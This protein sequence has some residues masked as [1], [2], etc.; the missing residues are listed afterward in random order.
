VDSLDEASE[1]LSREIEERM[2]PFEDRLVN[3]QTIP[4]V[5]DRTAEL[6]LSEVDP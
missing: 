2:R 4:G 6:I 1:K 5:G 3:L